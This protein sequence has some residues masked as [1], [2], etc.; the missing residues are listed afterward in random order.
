MKQRTEQTKMKKPNSSPKT[1]NY[2]WKSNNKKTRHVLLREKYYKN[3]AI[4]MET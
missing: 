3:N 4:K 2:F 1:A